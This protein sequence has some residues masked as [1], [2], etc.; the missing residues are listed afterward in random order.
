MEN[1]MHNTPN[2]NV[3]ILADRMVDALGNVKESQ[4]LVRDVFADALEEWAT[5]NGGHGASILH[6]VLDAVALNGDRFV[7][8]PMSSALARLNQTFTIDAK[9]KVNIDIKTCTPAMKSRALTI[10]AMI[11]GNEHFFD[12]RAKSDD[13]GKSN[14]PVDPY[15]GKSDQF[16]MNLAYEQAARWLEAQARKLRKDLPENKSADNLEKLAKEMRKNAK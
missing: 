4:K 13:D 9:G 10:I 7:A 11:R 15:A 12:Y 16:I 14:T 5:N 8:R 2:V 6:G 1:T 3:N